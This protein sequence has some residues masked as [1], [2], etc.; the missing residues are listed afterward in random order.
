MKKPNRPIVIPPQNMELL[1]VLSDA[2]CGEVM[3]AV[4]AYSAG[5]EDEPTLSS[6]KVRLV[7]KV[8]KTQF[9][10]PGRRSARYRPETLMEAIDHEK[11]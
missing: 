4:L 2:E 5:V 6:D 11:R 8:M 7:Y 1:Q 3:K 9:D 10:N